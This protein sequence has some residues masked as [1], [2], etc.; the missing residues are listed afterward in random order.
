MQT[1]LPYPDYKDSVSCLDKYRLGNQV[2]R[3]GKTLIS[4]GWPNHPA[5]FM[6]KGYFHQL[7]LYC[8]EGLH[9]LERRGLYY[10]QHFSYFEDMLNFHPPTDAPPWLGNEALH[11]SHRSNL[12]RK[13]PEWYGQFGW[14]EPDD[15]PYVWPITKNRGYVFGR[16]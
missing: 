2:Y 8:I 7:A 12:L 14:K 13:D 5:S 10:P 11:S 1:F 9:E 15:L 6:W 4:G 16:K 3:E